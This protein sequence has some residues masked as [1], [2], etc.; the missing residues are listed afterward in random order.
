MNEKVTFAQLVEELSD[1]LIIPKTR[2]QEFI[3]SL[4]DVVLEDIETHGKATITNFGSFNII[5]V[6]AR[7][8]INPK[9][10][11]PIEIPEHKR[12]SFTPYK[13][14]EKAVNHEFEHLVATIVESDSPD[15]SIADS[16]TTTQEKEASAHQ[17]PTSTPKDSNPPVNFEE[18]ESST[19]TT[20]DVKEESTATPPSLTAKTKVSQLP[21]RPQ[22]STGVNTGIILGVIAAFFLV[23]LGIWFFAFRTPVPKGT[24][25]TSSSIPEQSTSEA[26]TNPT[27][28]PEALLEEPKD[29]ESMVIPMVQENPD[30]ETNPDELAPTLRELPPK[31]SIAI[32]FQVES[33]VWIYEISRQ[34]YGNTRLWPLIFQANYTLDNDPDKILPNVHL[35]IPRLEG[36][37][38]QPSA[39]DYIRLAEAARYVADAYEFTGKP[40]K[41]A[42]YR[43]AANWYE[44]LADGN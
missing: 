6:A 17:H 42:A 21:G 32:Y 4:I 34:T 16:N 33:G 1:E 7:T 30:F 20:S 25:A 19:V 15:E 12:L 22:R 2:A 23:V 28:Q 14:L 43:K 24:S 36:T 35:E 41:A 40:E 9:T 37:T 27:E 29:V 38:L 10:G 3:N 5:K 8:G 44:A 39:T 26:V 13:A 18:T 11:E 31:E